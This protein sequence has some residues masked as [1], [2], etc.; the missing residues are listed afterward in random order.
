MPPSSDEDGQN[1]KNVESLQP[2]NSAKTGADLPRTSDNS[3][4]VSSTV[5]ERKD[6]TTTTTT[7][8]TTKS[9]RGVVGECMHSFTDLV[10]ENLI[11][12]RYGAF[13]G[14]C[15][16]TAYGLS[17]TPLFFRFRTISEVPGKYCFL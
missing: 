3:D 6:A 17:N 14:V 13:A 10:N 2:I 1:N 5:I 12:A 16:L 4:D 7:T 8:T 9:I 11:A 15:L